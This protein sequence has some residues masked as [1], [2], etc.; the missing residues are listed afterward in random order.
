MPTASDRVPKGPTLSL[1]LVTLIPAGV[2]F[3]LL[4]RTL[5]GSFLSDDFLWNTFLDHTSHE[6]KVVWSEL[7]RD[8]TGPWLGGEIGVFYRPL[9][10]ASFAL[11]FA[12]DG[13][14][15]HAFHVINLVHHVLSTVF[16]GLLCGLLCPVRPRL[17]ALVG[18]L[19]FA[20]HPSAVEPV[21]WPSS[22]TSTLEVTFRFGALA[23]F[24]WFRSTGRKTAIVLAWVGAVLALLTKESALIIPLAVLAVDVLHPAR[25]L[26]WPTLRRFA[27]FA[28]IAAAYI[29]L[30]TVLPG[31][32]LST[33][34]AAGHFLGSLP[35]T[36][37]TKIWALFVPFGI[38]GAP[39]WPGVAVVVALGATAFATLRARSLLATC[40]VLAWIFVQFLPSSTMLIAPSYFGARMVYGSVPLLALLV[41]IPLFGRKP[42]PSFVRNGTWIALLAIASYAS[43]A[44]Q[45]MD[46]YDRAF[47]DTRKI[48]AE[49]ER[50]GPSATPRM[51]LATL[52]SCP[53]KDGILR[54]APSV[55][56]ALAERPFANANYPVTDI[57]FVLSPVDASH[58]LFRDA[59]PIR[60]MA[61]FGATLLSWDDAHG[62]FVT[63]RVPPAPK[64][65]TADSHTNNTWRFRAPVSPFAIE[66]VRIRVPT[67]TTAK[68]L[69]WFTA[70]DLPAKTTTIRLTGGNELIDL[71][72]D[73]GFLTLRILGNVQG[74]AVDATGPVELEFL[75]R[76]PQ[77]PIP[78][79]LGGATLA[80]EDLVERIV[81]PQQRD[82]SDRMRMVL[83]TPATGLAIPVKDGR[84]VI[85]QMPR[86]ELH[87]MLRMA[88][89]R[90]CYYWFESK[91][92]KPMTS[93]SRSKVDWFRMTQRE[94]RHREQAHLD[95]H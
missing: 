23:A 48:I 87:R 52:S 8:F 30:R 1:L 11:G 28:A 53:E 6:T 59:E 15:A 22:A 36:L 14:T 68:S 54:H 60:A 77:L 93:A 55:S 64:H 58:V 56:Y 91:S 65:L 76:L 86:V 74:F 45:R 33:D 19:L 47:A 34:N 70:I 25:S 63:E 89:Q 4:Y 82:G 88:R 43:V 81:P 24:A 9:S 32:W 73:L 16:C 67:G 2:A 62:K 84:L 13:D 37:P 31:F 51:P 10:T 83:L 61:R 69:R 49:F 17:A 90:W 20:V 80:V 71:T 35:A 85:G 66:A 21:A 72:H 5:A 42:T 78:K 12:L 38:G 7:W 18:G 92:S 57:S 44:W 79:P 94:P 50:L 41:C 75:T 40:I 26:F 27:P 29:V 39:W 3:A 46:D 95:A